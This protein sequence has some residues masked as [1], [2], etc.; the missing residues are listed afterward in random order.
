MEKRTGFKMGDDELTLLGKEVKVGDK[1]PDFTVVKGDLSAFSLKDMGDKVKLLVAVPSIDTNVCEL[2]TIRF[3]EEADKLGD[4]VAIMV[5]SMDLP[6]AQSRF[7]A[8]KGI[9][10]LTVTSDYQQ[11]SF[12]E[13][14]GVLMEGLSLLNRS[15]FVVDKDNTVKYVEYVKQNT[16]HPDYDKALDAARELLK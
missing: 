3:N 2:E 14:Y 4:D 5:V 15:I 8:A 13:N 6:F 16:N 11:K 10:H 12:G 7:C 9:K 1:A